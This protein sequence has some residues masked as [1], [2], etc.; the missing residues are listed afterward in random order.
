M[1]TR[2]CLI[3][4]LFMPLF[5]FYSHQAKTQFWDWEDKIPLTDSISDNANP[6]LAHIYSQMNGEM[7]AMAWEKSTDETSTAIYFRD[8]LDPASEIAVISV[9]G[10]HFKNPKI[11]DLY[12]NDSSLFYL[13]FE[14]DE[15]G[16]QDLY[17]MKYSVD[18]QFA[19]PF[20]FMT[21]EADEYNL[22]PANDD[23]WMMT[24]E[25]R[26]VFTVLAWISDGDLYSCD[27][28]ILED[29]IGFTAPLLLDTGSCYDPVVA[30]QYLILYLKENSDSSFIYYVSKGWP[31]YEWGSPEVFFDEGD[32]FNLAGDN[33]T[34][35]YLTWSSDSSGIFRNHIALEWAPY[36]GYR[37][38]PES[39]VPLDPAICTIVIG[40]SP[41]PREFYDYFMAFPFTDS[42]NQEIFLNPWGNN[43][44]ADFS[45][46]GAECRNPDFFLGE[47]HPW[48]PWC[49]YVYLAWEELRSGH[50]QIMS[51]KTIMCVGGIDEAS[52]SDDFIKSW[53][54]PF[55]DEINL[56]YT[57]SS[58]ELVSIEVFDLFGRKIKEVF[59]GIQEEGEHLLNPNLKGLPAGIYLIRLQT[60]VF[61]SSTRVIKVN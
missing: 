14:S 3:I 45:Q 21:G 29:T 26:Y 43:Y 51:S 17:Y 28:E 37:I 27:V 8:L 34:P 10:V 39:S 55:R 38:G 46:S 44:F 53:P 60:S 33:V 7:V 42:V 20:A 58:N 40:V 5:F 22:N 6:D 54:N 13:F 2:P 4:F 48:N 15:N 11:L 9:P 16:N 30:S 1:K 52:E 49:F 35:N 41:E 24:K 50:W 32:C 19:G 18:G 23:M 57:L 36:E 31:T 59:S 25:G 56:N 47:I 12:E 61:Q